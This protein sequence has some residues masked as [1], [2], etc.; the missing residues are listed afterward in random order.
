MI[1]MD[2]VKPSSISGAYE[3][4]QSPNSR[5]IGGG[6]FLNLTGADIGKAID[7]SELNLSFID[8]NSDSIEIGAMT[9]LRDME[10]SHILKNLMGG[11]IPLAISEIM[12]VQVRNTATIGG[13]VWGRFGFSDILTSLLVLDTHV[14]LYHEGVMSLDN[15]LNGRF[16]NDILTKIIIKKQEG[17]AAFLSMRNVST[18]FSVLNTGVSRVTG[19]FKI[20]VGARPG[21]A[22][23]AQ[24]SMEFI[25]LH[26]V[27]SD[28]ADET[29]K[30]ASSTLEFGDDI[31]ASVSYRREICTVMVRRCITEVLK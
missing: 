14:S 13:T 23:L 26:E 20:A 28:V 21:R 19:N 24:K 6:L 16:R 31:R 9:T 22:C 18:D 8:E 11:I 1:V 30:I 5:I 4:L 27:N 2:Y 7:L 12:G 15:F 25:N 17:N 3:I 29:A 10:K